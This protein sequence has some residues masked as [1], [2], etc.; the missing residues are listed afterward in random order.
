L[1]EFEK[2]FVEFVFGC[3]DQISFAIFFFFEF[4][5]TF[6]INILIL[7]F[8]LL[9]LLCCL[10]SCWCWCRTFVS[11]I[12]FRKCLWYPYPCWAQPAACPLA[13]TPGAPASWAWVACPSSRDHSEMGT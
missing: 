1:A 3:C 7:K 6:R 5:L 13:R 10:L 2:N 9:M 4:V 8:S 12:G 11:G